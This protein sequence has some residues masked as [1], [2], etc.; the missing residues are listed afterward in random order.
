L[1]GAGKSQMGVNGGHL[2]KRYSQVRYTVKFLLKEP[3][4]WFISVLA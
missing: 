1:S 3:Y 4:V 2:M